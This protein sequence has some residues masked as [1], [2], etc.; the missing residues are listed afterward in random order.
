MNNHDLE[1]YVIERCLKLV[2]K[3]LIPDIILHFRKLKLPQILID[4]LYNENALV[5]YILNS[6][7]WM[8]YL[9]AKKIT[10][11]T[12]YN[13]SS[14]PSSHCLKGEVKYPDNKRIIERI[15]YW[16]EL[17]KQYLYLLKQLY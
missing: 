4:F 6:Y 15:K 7:E 1:D 3:E 2:D 10:L 14:S 16:E 5:W 12:Y 13:R 9:R 17:N 8:I 11:T